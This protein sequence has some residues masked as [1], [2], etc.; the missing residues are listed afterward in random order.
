MNLTE[1]QKLKIAEIFENKR[2]ERQA[3][4]AQGIN[5]DRSGRYDVLIQLKEILTEEQMMQVKEK[6]SKRAYPSKPHGNKADWMRKNGGDW[7][8]DDYGARKREDRKRKYEKNAKHYEV[9]KK[10][11]AEFDSD[12]KRKDKKTI[13]EL[14][15]AHAQKIEK[16]K[17]IKEEYR[18]ATDKKAIWSKIEALMQEEKANNWEDLSKLLD[19]YD[20]GINN[21]FAENESQLKA[22][23]G[24]RTYKNPHAPGFV[25]KYMG[26]A[27]QQGIRSAEGSVGKRACPKNACSPE[28]CAKAGKSCTAADCAKMGKA[29]SPEDCAKMGIKCTPEDCA[30]MGKTC[31][32]ADC[33]KMGKTCSPE[34]CAKMGKTCSPADC[35]KMGKTCTP[36]DC[37]KMGIKCDPSDC[38]KKGKKSKY[39][40]AEKAEW[41]AKK[42][43]MRNIKFLLMDFNAAPNA[44]KKSSI[45]VFAEVSSIKC[46]PNPASSQTTVKYNV[47]NAGEITVE[48]RDERGQLV[49]TIVNEY[50][51]IGTYTVDL[52]TAELNSRIYFVTI[53]DAVGVNSDKLIIYN[54]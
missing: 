51:E 17:A 21:I 54:K 53:I 35:A 48:V 32:P 12:I 50:K 31:S 11:R 38:D 18:N 4:T 33:A 14:R 26:C 6:M 45:P 23:K 41:K 42:K 25:G 13:I 30:K 46:F 29:C 44:K 28:D 39:S 7:K 24:E 10:M 19:K 1:D 47:I 37:A 27:G 22:L 3:N 2:S 9:L 40:E 15:N 43:K 52:S 5:S 16:Y 49:N 8:G 20:D 34:D 36:E